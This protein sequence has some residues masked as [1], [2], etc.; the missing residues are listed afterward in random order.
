M[1][2]RI[3][4]VEDDETVAR[5]VCDGMA[6]AGVEI[7]HAPDAKV[8]ESRARTERFD[9]MVFDRQLPGGVD[10]ADLLASLRASGIAT[11]VLFLSGLGG[12]QDWMKGMETGGDDYLVKP[13][14]FTELLSRVQALHERDLTPELASEEGHQTGG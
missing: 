9:V 2:M 13:F 1:D 10:G 4:L 11:P 8:G 6:E 14:Q 7:V 12:L 5:L 3:L